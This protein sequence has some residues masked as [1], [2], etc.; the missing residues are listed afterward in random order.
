MLFLCVGLQLRGRE[1]I[2]RE[3]NPTH[4]F[5][6]SKKNTCLNWQQQLW[7][8]KIDQSN[9]PA[10]LGARGLSTDEPLDFDTIIRSVYA[11]PDRKKYPEL[12]KL[13]PCNLCTYSFQTL[14]LVGLV[15]NNKAKNGEKDNPE[16]LIN[17]VQEIM[18][19]SKADFNNKC[20]RLWD[21]SVLTDYREGHE[22]NNGVG[23]TVEKMEYLGQVKKFKWYGPF[24]LERWHFFYIYAVEEE[25][26]GGF[27]IELE[28]QLTREF[29]KSF[30]ANSISLKILA[31]KAKVSN[32]PYF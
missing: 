11:N 18:P 26:T 21:I 24:K 7:K 15:E 29:P 31:G 17:K 13:Q 28:I 30:F 16:Y 20:I 32:I 27:Y 9:D 14:E 22:F 2:L 3:I 6:H 12:W 1:R 10:I 8:K 25:A 5:D 4:W 23:P 19:N